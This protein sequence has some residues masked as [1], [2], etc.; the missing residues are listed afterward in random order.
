MLR[1]LK[2]HFLPYQDLITVYCSYIRPICEY[3]CPVWHGGLTVKQSSS[4][5]SVQK[6]ALR[7][8]LGNEFSSYDDAL[9]I[10]NLTSL[11]KRRENLCL[12]FMKK[13][14]SKTNQFQEYLPPSPTKEIIEK[15]QKVNWHQ[16][17]NKQNAKQCNSISDKP[18]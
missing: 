18:N 11:S 15:P 2:R 13:T 1:L 4:L 8:I 3:G 9:N 6:R 14:L 17:Q 12:S 16:M 7:I 10:C 5:E